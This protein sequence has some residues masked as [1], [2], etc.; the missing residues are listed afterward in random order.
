MNLM[1]ISKSE[2]IILLWLGL[3]LVYLL[4]VAFG[5]AVDYYDTF[6]IFLNA[7]GIVSLD[8]TA[9]YYPS[10]PFVPIALFS[11][12]FVLEKFIPIEDFAFK[13]CH[14]LSAT[15]FIALLWVFYRLL[16]LHLE[17]KYALWGVFLLSLNPLLIRMVPISKEDIPGTLF[18][19]AAFAS[20]LEGTEGNKIRNF[21]ISGLLIFASMGTRYHFIP[22]LFLVIALYE[23]LRCRLTLRIPHLKTKLLS[24][25]ILPV[26]LF[27]LIPMIVYPLLGRASFLTAPRA[28]IELMFTM[29]ELL[30]HDNSTLLLCRFLIRSVTA[31]LIL[32]GGLGI[33]LS[34]KKAHAGVLF[35]SLWL[36]IFFLFLTY[37]VPGSDTRSL[38][39]LFPPL[40]FFIV[41]G[42]E[43]S[44][45]FLNRLSLS[46][47]RRRVLI[48][49]F[50]AA[51]LTLPMGKAIRACYRFTDPIYWVNFEKEVSRYARTL[52][53]E[54]NI[55]WV[56]PVYPVHPKDFI[57][58]LRDNS[59]FIYDFYAHVV[60]FYTGKKARGLHW[61]EVS[62]TV[63]DG[64]VLILNLE[65][66]AHHTDSIP[67]DLK[68][69]VVKRA[70][71]GTAL[72]IFFDEVRSFSLPKRG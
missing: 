59:T 51:F 27:F 6:K 4:F 41:R 61:P 46:S 70:R 1:R 54:N 30:A 55:F 40:Y 53:G 44:L 29:R 66:Q 31:S 71:I 43:E 57:F 45:V 21:F 35:H 64:D 5:M 56:G 17:S 37:A 8:K 49:A 32:L 69:L 3:L 62:R 60:R 14:L 48:S 52:A 34:W 25:F 28:L 7:R 68:P 42:L 65:K 38:L 12:I 39:P 19:T 22:P 23:I 15:L 67:R 20:Y 9:D 72:E 33:F 36:G 24:L 63:R 58:D 16:C 10:R 47:L 18:I 2:V 26:G 11:P 50:F 13:A